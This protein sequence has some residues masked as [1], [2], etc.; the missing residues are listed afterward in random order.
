MYSVGRTNNMLHYRV[1][2][3]GSEHE[4]INPEV[5][6]PYFCKDR[7]ILATSE[8]TIAASEVGEYEK[9]LST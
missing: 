4:N 8:E 6:S 9:G 7:G 2:K 1:Q 5:H 3:W